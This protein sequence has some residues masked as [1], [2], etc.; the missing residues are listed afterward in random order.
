LAGI[1][2]ASPVPVT[3]IGNATNRGFRAAIN[4]GLENARG[5]D[6]VLLNISFG[7]M[8]LLLRGMWRWRVPRAIMLFGSML[9][10]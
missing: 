8:T 2:D 4:Q 3:V 9:M 1:Q 10:I 5:E 7:L 6:L